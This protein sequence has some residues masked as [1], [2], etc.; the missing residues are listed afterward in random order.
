M[1]QFKKAVILMGVDWCEKAKNE[2]LKKNDSKIDNDLT[3]DVDATF[4]KSYEQA[5]HS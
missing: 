3:E 5:G 2:F 4:R 1:K